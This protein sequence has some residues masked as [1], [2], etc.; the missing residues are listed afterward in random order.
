MKQDASDLPD[1]ELNTVQT[2]RRSTVGYL[3]HQLMDV[4][5]IPAFYCCYLLRSTVRHANLYIGST[6]NPR[7]RLAQHNG[8]VKGGAVRTSRISLRPWEM[9]CVVAGFP[10][11]IAALQFEWAWQNAHLTRHIPHED[12]ISFA[13]TRTKTS[14][15]TGRTRK[16]PARPKASLTDRL[17]NLHLL[18]R[19]PY[20]SKWPLELRFFSEDVYRFWQSWCQR[21]D[22]QISSDVKVWLGTPKQDYAQASQDTATSQKRRKLDLI[23]KEGVNGIDPTYA[24]LQPVLEKSEM[25]LEEDESLACGLCKQS[26]NVK[27]DLITACPQAECQSFHHMDCLSSHFLKDDATSLLFPKGGNCPSCKANLSWPE[28]MKEMTLR[29]RGAKEVQK[30][31]RHKKRAAPARVLEAN[32]LEEEVSD[33]FD[34]EES[35]DGRLVA[36]D[37][38]DESGD[39]AASVTSVESDLSRSSTRGT[40]FK[41]SAGTKLFSVIEDSDVDAI[42]LIS[43]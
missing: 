34:V 26:L 22:V 2:T 5:P 42:D 13:I 7:R 41:H 38:V 36:A 43:D 32:I 27:N 14:P 23:G 31:L 25:L 16:R 24:S 17:S 11:N 18:L 29:V 30:I 20:F 35:D 3:I 39:D 33:E 6:P 1:P 10:S 4:K 40:V 9:T 28:L 37:V 21:V 8:Q 12:R 15:K 19:V